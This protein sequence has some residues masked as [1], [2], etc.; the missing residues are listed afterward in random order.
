MPNNIMT[1]VFAAVFAIGAFPVA[2]QNTPTPQSSEL[3]EP[4]L[5]PDQTYIDV[6]VIEFESLSGPTK[7]EV[8]AIIE[9]TNADELHELQQTIA[10]SRQALLTLASAGL[11]PTHVLA[12]GV[13]SDG[14]LTLVVQQTA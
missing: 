10:D 2:A 4:A 5:G 9:D 11:D 7:S 1:A 13:T 12:A 8:E 3:A 6:V 14:V